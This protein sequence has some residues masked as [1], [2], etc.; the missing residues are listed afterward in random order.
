MLPKS[1]LN[2]MNIKLESVTKSHGGSFTDTPQ[3]LSKVAGAANKR[4][5]ELMFVDVI[6]LVFA[7]DSFN[8]YFTVFRKPGHLNAGARRIWRI[9]V[10]TI[11][12]VDYRK[13]I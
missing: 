13:I 5:F 10:F 7:G 12:V 4:D 1:I 9:K 11:D 2:R 3:G 8:F 6:F